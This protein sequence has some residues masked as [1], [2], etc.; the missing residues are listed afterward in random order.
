MIKKIIHIAR[1]LLHFDTSPFDRDSN[2]VQD[3]HHGNSQCMVMP[4]IPYGCRWVKHSQSESRRKKERKRTTICV[5]FS[6][7]LASSFSC[8][9]NIYIKNRT[10][11]LFHS[12]FQSNLGWIVYRSIH[13]TDTEVLHSCYWVTFEGNNTTCDLISV[14]LFYMFSLLLSHHLILLLIIYSIYF[15]REW[16]EWFYS[17]EVRRKKSQ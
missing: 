2:V 16:R 6:C 4:L 7:I 1:T 8:L 5:S 3:F 10:P 12:F 9:V 13:T 15:S 11:S 17:Q 14:L